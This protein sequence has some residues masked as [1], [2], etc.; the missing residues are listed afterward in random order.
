MNDFITA[1]KNYLE[2]EGKSVD[3]LFFDNIISKDTFYK[4]KQRNPSLQTLIKVANYWQVSIDYLYE[5][6]DVNNFSKYSNDQSKFYEYLTELIRKANLSNRQFCKEMNYQKDNILR[7]K[8]GTT[9]SLR[10]LFEIAEYFGCFVD[11]LLTKE[12]NEKIKNTRSF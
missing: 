8:Y 1:V 5:K 3:C 12:R 10:T 9:P 4:Y 6:T 11:D 7:Y 2:D